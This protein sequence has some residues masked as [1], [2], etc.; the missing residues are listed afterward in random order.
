M[1]KQN[2]GNGKT[3]SQDDP[4]EKPI[5]RVLVLGCRCRC[6]YEWLPRFGETPRVC[7]KCKSPNWDKPKR[8]TRKSAEAE[9]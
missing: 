4:K 6:G 1:A 8:W 7:P 3:R 5:G 9:S 2:P